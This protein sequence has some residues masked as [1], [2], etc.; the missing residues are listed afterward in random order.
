MH[1]ATRCLPRFGNALAVLVLLIA[2][3]DAQG[4]E[5]PA[6]V[7]VLQ[8][9][10]D[11]QQRGVEFFAANQF[12]AARVEFE[13]TL[14]LIDQVKDPEA[15]AAILFNLA[16]VAEKQGRL[17]DSL[18]YAKR[19]QA[20]VPSASSDEQFVKLLKRLEPASAP[21]PEPASAP[22]PEPARPPSQPRPP[23]PAAALLG[24]G[25]GALL[26]SLI[27]TVLSGQLSGR[28]E[29]TPVTPG[30]LAELTAEGGRL[31]GAAI[32]LATVGFGLAAAGGIWLGVHYGRQHKTP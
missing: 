8:T 1:L 5:A 20:L 29:G 3:L 23:V 11:H 15:Y 16:L 4:Q 10:K 19:H 14:A 25:G 7:D 30:E 26:A 2:S 24:V 22:K 27:V 31:N 6:L 21:K 32:G 28:V 13:A 9:A 12:D 18:G 17:D